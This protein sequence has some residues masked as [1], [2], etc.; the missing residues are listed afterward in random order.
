M[1]RRRYLMGHHL[2]N[3][4]GVT[5]LEL[6]I[7]LIIIGISAGTISALVILGFKFNENN[8]SY[9][10]N[11]RAATSCYETLVA[12]NN[13]ERWADENNNK[14]FVEDCT[15]QNS[16]VFGENQLSNWIQPP[17]QLANACSIEPKPTCG[18]IKLD[19]SS[20]TGD[21]SI[22]FKIPIEGDSNLE[23]ILPIP[24]ENI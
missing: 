15:S 5:L 10:E 20:E 22:R 8:E 17:S 18:G 14:I 3:E 23:L 7:A 6:I 19:Q 11:L 2:T 13:N 1:Q 12:I 24:E 4:D 21:D 9:A 16:F